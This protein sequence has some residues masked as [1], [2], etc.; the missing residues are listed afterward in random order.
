MFK[1]DPT[2][3]P[4]KH[5]KV[6][7]FWPPEFSLLKVFMSGLSGGGGYIVHTSTPV[8]A[9]EVSNA[10]MPL[11]WTKMNVCDPSDPSSIRTPRSVAGPEY[12]ECFLSTS[13]DL[14]I[15]GTSGYK[16]TKIADLEQMP[17]LTTLILR[18]HL[19]EKMENL[20]SLSQLEKLELYD[21]QIEALE[22]L[23]VSERALWK[24]RAMISLARVDG[25][26]CRV[27]DSP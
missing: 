12:D 4:T 16:V 11:D 21:N 6:Q 15:I 13:T 26:R 1:L 3:I 14:T 20:G 10:Q 5:P 23:E 2:N 8:P 7:F 27:L 19:I 18:S 9:S 22:D 25:L 24:T 17:L